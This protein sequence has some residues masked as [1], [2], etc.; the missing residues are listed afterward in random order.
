MLTFGWKK[1]HSIVILDR[2]LQRVVW[3][4]LK[5]AIAYTIVL[6]RQG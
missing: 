5:L 4:T 6:D 3:A 1:H 2:I